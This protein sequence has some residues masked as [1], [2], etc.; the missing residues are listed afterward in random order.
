MPRSFKLAIVRARHDAGV[1]QAIPDQACLEM[2]MTRA[3]L[4]HE[5]LER[6]QRRLVRL[7]RQ[8]DDHALG[9]YDHRPGGDRPRQPA[10]R[11]LRGAGAANLGIDPLAGLT[12]AL[13]DLARAAKAVVATFYGREP[14]FAYF[15]GVSNGGRQALS[16]AQRYPD[17]FDGILAGAPASNWAPM[18]GLAEAWMARANTDEK[19]LPILTSEKLPALHAAVL[20]ACADAQGVITDPRACA[21]DPTTIQCK[22]TPTPPTA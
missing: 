14:T 10:A 7:S 16:L 3:E 9:R 6:H 15:S 5:L 12:G 21:F 13:H 4:G 2:L 20:G 1:G 8:R 11:R 18:V 22:P 17:D 19:G